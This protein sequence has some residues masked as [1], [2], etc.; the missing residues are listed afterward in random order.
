MKTEQMMKMTP[1]DLDAYARLL[2]FS[3]KGLGTAEE[4][5]EAIRERRSRCVKLRLIGVDVTVPIR[6]MHDKR[7]TDLLAKEDKTDAETEGMARLIVGDDAWDELVEA[8]T[9]EDG[10]IDNEA[11]TLAVVQVV[12][13]PK[14]KNF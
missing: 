6:R 14:L 10:T 11:L 1:E 2:G 5:A 13:S 7:V 12:Y 4:K 9:D 8:A 3:V